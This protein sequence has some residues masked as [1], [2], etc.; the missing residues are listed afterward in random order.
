MRRMLQILGTLVM[1]LLAAAPAGAQSPTLER[2]VSIP[3]GAAPL[4]GTLLMPPGDAR[5]PAALILAGS[6]PTDRN[7]NQPTAH[8]DNLKLLAHG[9]FADGIATLR[10]DKRGIAASSPAAV[11]EAEL[12]LD[13]YVADAKAWLAF[14]RAQPRVSPVFIIGHSEGALIA[15]LAAPD[16]TLGGLVL[17]AGIGAPLGTVMRR[18]LTAAP[19]PE[20]L[21]HKA[22]DIIAALE[23]G[24]TVRD[25]PPELSA[26]FRPSVQPYTISS[27][28][29]DPVAALAASKTPALVVQGTTDL[30]VSVDDAKRLAAS[31]N[32]VTLVII[33]GMNHTLK[34][35]PADRAAQMPAYLNPDLPL[36]PTL[37]P[38]I[39]EFI[40]R[41]AP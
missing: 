21:R 35:A 33:D 17:I 37:V 20:P 8:T 3:G 34:T 22:F 25:V 23:R 26:L 7:G 27:L 19:L 16:E 31:R 14:L 32:G 29:R 36:A 40:R 12:R 9:L 1:T 2:N 39:A 4:R 30:Q 6:G 15:S 24:E 38:T 41:H 11:S 18:Q 5:V 28:Q 13:H 10:V